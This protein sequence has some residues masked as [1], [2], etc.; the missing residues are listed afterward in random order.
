M[1]GLKRVRENWKRKPQI[2]P[3]RSPRF[4][5]ELGGV[6][7]LHASFSTESRIRGRC[8]SREVLGTLVRQTFPRKVRG[9]ADPSA[10]LGV[11]DLFNFRCSLR[12]ESSQEHP[13]GSVAG[14]LGRSPVEWCFPSCQ[15]C[16]I[17]RTH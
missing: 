1:D 15:N 9:T 8:E 6:G 11:C 3:L 7:K 2:P 5:V 17:K 10:S 4:P 13:P 12:P 14:A 16:S